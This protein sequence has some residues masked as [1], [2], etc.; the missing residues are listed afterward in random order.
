LAAY[1]H[2]RENFSTVSNE[3]WIKDDNDYVAKFTEGIIRNRV[4]YNSK[5]EFQC[6][7]KSY[8]AELLNPELNKKVHDNFDGYAIKTVTELSNLDA[9]V[10][11]I[12]IENRESVKKLEYLDGKITVTEEYLNGG[13]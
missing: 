13:L 7:M 6:A 2:F 12:V 4:Y 10:Y 5:G 1:R 9:V 3:D 11:Y 8:G